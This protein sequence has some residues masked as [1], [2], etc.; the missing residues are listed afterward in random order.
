MDSVAPDA[1]TSFLRLPLADQLQAVVT[2]SLHALRELKRLHAQ[3]VKRDGYV[4]MDSGI[5]GRIS[6]KIR[7]ESEAMEAFLAMPQSEQIAWIDAMADPKGGP[8]QELCALNNEYVDWAE[9]NPSCPIGQ[10][11]AL[12]VY[13]HLLDRADPENYC[14]LAQDSEQQADVTPEGLRRMREDSYDE[15]RPFLQSDVDS[16]VE[17]VAS[18]TLDDCREFVLLIK[19]QRGETG[20]RHEDARLLLQARIELLEDTK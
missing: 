10:Q 5:E 6:A 9:D 12:R 16:Q 11:L 19:R 13:A 7:R 8:S 1:L 14:A 18:L 17:F 15:M 20:E 4:T 2:L 3:A